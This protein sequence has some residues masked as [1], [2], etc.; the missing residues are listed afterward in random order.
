MWHNQT[1]GSFV[2]GLNDEELE[3]VRLAF[4]ELA[5]PATGLL[6]GNQV[7]LLMARLKLR[8]PPPAPPVALEEVNALVVAERRETV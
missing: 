2:S 3:R 5:D 7:G 8:G 4:V 1:P 6:Q